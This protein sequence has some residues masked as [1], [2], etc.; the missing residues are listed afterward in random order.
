MSVY[1]FLCRD[2]NRFMLIFDCLRVKHFA[3]I[4]LSAQLLYAH[5]TSL[6]S[7]LSFDQREAGAS[8]AHPGEA[9]RADAAGDGRRGREDSASGRGERRQARRRG[10]G[11]D[12]VDQ[13]DVRRDRQAQ[14]RAGEQHS[15]DTS[16]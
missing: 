6:L 9:E 16:R 2:M 3:A 5:Y 7:R 13:E 10:E 12:R 8:G 1:K 15:P 4:F 14:E 11:Q